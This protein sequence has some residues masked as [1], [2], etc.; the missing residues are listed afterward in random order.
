M[1]LIQKALFAWACFLFWAVATVALA[2]DSFDAEAFDR[3]ALR[4]EE[5]VA[6]SEASDDALENLRQQLSDFRE[7]ALAAQEDSGGAAKIIRDQI[8]ALGPAPSEGE[9]EPKEVADRRAELT[10][11]LDVAMAPVRSAKASYE[12]ADAIIKAID[13]IIRQ[14]QA[15][16][17]LTLAPT[18]L[19]PVS[20]PAALGALSGHL[21]A[22]GGEV[23]DQWG[24]QSVI[25]RLKQNAPVIL[26]LLVAGLAMIVPFLRWSQRKMAYL[27]AKE[28]TLKVDLKQLALSVAVFVIPVIGFTLLLQAVDLTNLLGLR[29]EFLRAAMVLV[30]VS[31]FGAIWLARNLFATDGPA[32]RLLGID[33]DKLGGGRWTVQLLG[34]VLAGKF[35]LDAIAEGADWSETTIGVLTFPL[36]LL[37]GLGIFRL[38][39]KYQVYLTRQAKLDETGEIVNPATDRFYRFIIWFLFA[40]SVVGPVLA[41]IGYV[42]AGEMIV[43]STLLSL[44]LAGALVIAYTLLVGFLQIFDPKPTAQF[45]GPE[46]TPARVGSVG[47][48]YRV[49]L[50]FLLICVAVPVLSLIWGARTSDL[51]DMWRYLREGISL[52]ETRLSLSDFLTFIAIFFIGYTITRLCQSAL[53]TSVLPN[54]RINLGAQNA[55]V[56]G[57]GY[58]GIFLS[59]LVAIMSTGLDLSNLAIVAGALSVGIGFGLQAIVSNFVSGIILLIERPIKLGDWVEIGGFSGYVRNISVRSTSIETFDRSTVIVPNADLISGTVTNY[60]HE[61]AYGRVKVPVGVAYGTNPRLV[62][63]ILLEIASEHPMVR[64]HPAPVVMFKGFGA[65][66]LD[67]ELRAILEDVNWVASTASDMNYRI[68]ERFAEEKIDIPFAQREV[69]IKNVDAIGSAK[70]G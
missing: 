13:Q 40:A 22:V 36:I 58:V 39:R 50:G 32:V 62:E 53:R 8:D 38:T 9:S 24:T 44:A 18:P 3:A 69:F 46:D 4:A 56:T 14:R 43:F 29:G 65:D 1:K 68:V 52:G 12:R 15:D 6:K 35:L 25:Q 63:S 60:T 7:E 26:L 48:L 54:T 17:L 49:G 30:A 37:G 42:N 47:G 19:N 45:A 21:G 5:V 2:Q 34:W 31:I 55:L 11:S 70:E 20:W 28:E 64:A 57:F 67:F 61:N 33:Q 27:G 23:A 66:S 16:A 51:G 41:A 59:A 10:G